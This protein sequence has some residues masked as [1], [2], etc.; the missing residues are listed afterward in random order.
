MHTFVSKQVGRSIR[1]RGMVVVVPGLAFKAGLSWD[2]DVYP[3][4]FVENV[5]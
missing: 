4:N 3:P 1:E 5:F 2:R